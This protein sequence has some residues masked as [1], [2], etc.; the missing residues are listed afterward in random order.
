[1]RGPQGHR[2]RPNA[3]LAEFETKRRYASALSDDH[4]GVNA[5]ERY[6]RRRE[7]YKVTC[8]WADERIKLLSHDKL[9]DTLRLHLRE[10]S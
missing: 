7:A 2:G 6:P 4:R 10:I 1:M 3:E 9:R 8:L 5:E